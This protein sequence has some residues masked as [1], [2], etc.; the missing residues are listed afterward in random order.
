M[1]TRLTLFHLLSFKC[2]PWSKMSGSQLTE[3]A[4]PASLKTKWFREKEQ[5]GFLAYSWIYFQKW[6][7]VGQTKPQRLLCACSSLAKFKNMLCWLIR[8]ASPVTHLKGFEIMSLHVFSLNHTIIQKNCFLVCVFHVVR[9]LLFV[10]SQRAYQAWKRKGHPSGNQFVWQG[11][12]E[13]V[14]RE[15]EGIY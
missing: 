8:T 5:S 10:S 15:R 13:P 14:C 1:I 11:R 7:W 3:C 9:P 4:C 6:E 2:Q 12:P